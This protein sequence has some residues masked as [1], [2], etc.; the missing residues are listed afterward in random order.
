[1][2]EN[3][4]FFAQQIH[5]PWI[6]GVK[7]NSIKI[8]EWLNKKI[9]VNIISHRWP[10]NRIFFDKI[11]GVNIYYL[12]T[13]SDNKFLQIIYLFIW[14]FKSLTFV[15]RTRPKKI[16]VQYLDLSYLLCL[17]IIKLFKPHTEIIL[18]LYSTDEV[19]IIYKKIFLKF[20]PFSKIII[21]SEYLRDY[22]LK[23][24][25]DNLDIIYIP[26]S[27]DKSRYLN[28]SNYNNRDKKYILFSAGP[29][30]D[31]WSYFMIDLAQSMPEYQFI[32]AMRKFNAKSEKQVYDLQ[33]YISQKNVNNIIIKRNILKMED[34]LSKVGYLILPLQN[35]HIKMLIPVALLEAMACWTICFVSNLP[36]LS[37]LVDNKINAIVFNKYD[38]WDLKEKIIKYRDSE[39][40]SRQ[41]YNFAKKHPSFEE[42]IKDYYKLI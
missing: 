31:A 41:A 11:N 24:W 15:I 23:L 13:L 29:M 18:T 9:N 6:E 16:F 35:I 20:F 7:N 21:I 4:L 5:K 2:N 38:I 17:I 14:A 12:L 32:F 40:I 28:Y 27:Y 33:E 30:L 10:H 39:K 1:M 25:Y 22:L 34:L 36:N 3:I 8:C 42:I 19:T 26:L 37:R